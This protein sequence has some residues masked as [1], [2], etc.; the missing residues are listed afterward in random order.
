MKAIMV[1]FDTLNRHMLP[2]YSAPGDDWV[3]A[4]NF[5]RLAQRTVTFDNSYV[6][7]MPCMPARRELHTG[8]LNFLHR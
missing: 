8:R 6:G 1:M 7:S 4:P 3:H 2:P 5:Q